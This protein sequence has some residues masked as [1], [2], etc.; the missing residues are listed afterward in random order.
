[1]EQKKKHNEGESRTGNEA[2][3][4]GLELDRYFSGASCRGEW[5][6]GTRCL[7]AVKIS[8]ILILLESSTRRNE[9]DKRICWR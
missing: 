4:V 3:D 9:N 1:M 6:R 2:L 8:S 7:S 5:I